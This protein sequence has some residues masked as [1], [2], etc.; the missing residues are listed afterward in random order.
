MLRGRFGSTSGQPYI[1][2][3]VYIPRLGVVGNVSFLL[4][5]GAE[6]TVLMPADAQTLSVDYDALR[7]RG[8]SVGLGGAVDLFREPARL[9]F[10]GSG[11]FMYGYEINLRV[12]PAGDRDSL[13]VPSLLGRNVIDRWRITYDRS[14]SELTARVVSYDQRWV[15]GASAGT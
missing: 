1:A 7:N 12:Y 10:A 8:S 3:R 4:D 2:A 13:T 5:T 9:A 14:A 15:L 6:S 11:G